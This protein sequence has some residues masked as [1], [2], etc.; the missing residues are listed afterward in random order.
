MNQLN[1]FDENIQLTFEMEE[2]NKLAFLDMMVIRNTNDAINTTVYQKP[3]NPDIYINWH[4]HS[5]LQWKKTTANVLIQRA[6]KICSDK[7]FFD[8]E[9]DI[10]KHNLC[11]VQNYPRKFVQNIIDYNLHKRN[12][13]A[14]NLNEGNNSKAIFINCKYAGQK[15][16]Q[17]ISKMKK[18]VRNSLKDGVKPK[19]V[20]NSAKLTQYFNVKDPVPQK[21]KSGLVYNCT[22]PQIDCNESYICE[23]ERRFEECIIDHN[24]HSSGN[25]HSHV[26]LDNFQIVGRNYGNSIKRKIGAAML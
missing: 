15:G 18:I 25:S 13:I 6:I 1:S 10:I 2:E 21:Y 17:L 3:P 23:T 26:W 12:S 22:C 11:E 14:P 16:E 8:E 7:K 9:L 20:Y 5:L 24:K 19:V 4:S